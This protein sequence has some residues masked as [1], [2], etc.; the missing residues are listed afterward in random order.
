MVTRQPPHSEEAEA[1]VLGSILL[2]ASR[3]LDICSKKKMTS[4]KVEGED[5]GDRDDITEV[6]LPRGKA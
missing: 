6:K 4:V 5:C 1:G 3:V 2:D